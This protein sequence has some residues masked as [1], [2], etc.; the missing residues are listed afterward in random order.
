MDD[1]NP[2][3]PYDDQY[4][5]QEDP[6]NETDKPSPPSRLD[7]LMGAKERS[8]KE[9]ERWNEIEQRGAPLPSHDQDYGVTQPLMSEPPRKE[10]DTPTGR[11]TPPEGTPHPTIAPGDTPSGQAT[12]PGQPKVRPSIGSG[13][14][15]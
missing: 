3:N 10:C 5:P 11:D 6:P 14:P 1:Q 15:H 4:D 7:R 12:P 9:A 8:E 2:N 13:V